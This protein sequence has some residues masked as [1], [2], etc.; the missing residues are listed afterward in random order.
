MHDRSGTSDQNT[1]HGDNNT[2]GFLPYDSY[3][4]KID[5][6][7][8]ED[9]RVKGKPFTLLEKIKCLMTTVREDSH[10]EL[11][12]EKKIELFNSLKIRNFCS[13]KDTIKNNKRPQTEREDIQN[14]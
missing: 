5:S 3:H 4:T 2:T 12:T 6:S 7:Q 1:I 13:C 14:M 11:A 9:L 10:K 8:I